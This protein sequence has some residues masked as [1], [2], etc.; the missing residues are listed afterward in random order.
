MAEPFRR[1]NGCR[2]K[3]TEQ[4]GPC[5]NCNG[6]EWSW[7]FSVRLAQ[8]DGSVRQILRSGFDRKQDAETALDD[9]KA[10][11]RTGGV[12][13]A[14]TRSNTVGEY[15]LQWLEDRQLAVG[16]ASA[17]L[18]QST[19]DA[20]RLHVRYLLG[21]EYVKSAGQV[22]A[23]APA[24]DPDLLLPDLRSQH[25]E[26]AYRTLATRPRSRAPHTPLSGKTIWNAHNTLSAALGE[27]LD[28]KRVRH[29]EAR[30]AYRRALGATPESRRSDAVWTREQAQAF[31]EAL[32]GDPLQLVFRLALTRGLRRGEALGLTWDHVD[33]D[34]AHPQVRVRQALTKDG[35]G[36]PKTKT[37]VRDVPLGPSLVQAFRARRAQQA[38]E[39]LALGPSWRNPANLVFTRPDTLR[40]ADRVL[41]PMGWHPDSIT[42]LMRRT[43]DAQGLPWIGV[44]GLRHTYA[45]VALRAGERM[46]T[47]KDALGHD[48]IAT[49]V[50]IYGHVTDEDIRGAGSAV[51]EALGIG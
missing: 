20:N 14:R 29:N 33:I 23:G 39:R 24:L 47:V 16:I 36:R 37:S 31:L 43:V 19:V 11:A 10:D 42:S 25:V 2:R 44:H 3:R 41:P 34:G 13:P 17:K 35:L 1:C 27:A 21:D 49:T 7:A 40:D 28:A 45:T 15:L 6:L 9:L 12:A 8:A 38:E 18:R 4:R 5:P 50:D 48:S 51:D 26:R 30:G 32:D 46:D 22:R